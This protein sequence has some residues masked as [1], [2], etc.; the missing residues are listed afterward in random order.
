MT[1]KGYIMF[2]DYIKL[3]FD[4]KYA[5]SSKFSEKGF[6]LLE[7]GAKLIFDKLIKVDDL[8]NL[9]VIEIT[10]TGGECFKNSKAI[11]I[12]EYACR[13]NFIITILTNGTY[14][15]KNI[16]HRLAKLPISEVRISIYGL[17]EFHDNFTGV[18][19]SFNKSVQALEL[20]NNERSGF[21]QGTGVIT[22]NNLVI[23]K[24]S[25]YGV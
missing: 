17:E 5:V 20:L 19:R 23:A 24:E 13:Y 6:V 4:E 11:E 2:E 9:G 25:V 22:K 14:I 18:K 1:Q 21:A 8:Y 12:I 3:E 10:F 16:A 7:K 15:T